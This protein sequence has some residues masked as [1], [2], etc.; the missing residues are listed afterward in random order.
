MRG[1]PLTNNYMLCVIRNIPAYAGK[2]S[3]RIVKNT[4]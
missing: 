3:S 4:P 2:T 1:K